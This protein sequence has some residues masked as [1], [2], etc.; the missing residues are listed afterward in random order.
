MAYLDDSDYETPPAPTPAV[1]LEN[2]AASMPSPLPKRSNVVKGAD[3]DM[4]AINTPPAAP[5]QS[6]RSRRGRAAERS[7]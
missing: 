1:E 4:R 7:P 2:V 3:L 6:H 5:C